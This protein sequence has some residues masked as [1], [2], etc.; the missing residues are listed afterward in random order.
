MNPVF[1]LPSTICDASFGNVPP[2]TAPPPSAT[3]S[4]IPYP[5]GLRFTLRLRWPGFFFARRRPAEFDRGALAFFRRFV[6]ATAFFLLFAGL[7]IVRLI[8]SPKFLRGD[9]RRALETVRRFLRGAGLGLVRVRCF[10][11]VA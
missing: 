8:I 9:L 10:L 1:L 4:R 3:R 2:S 5:P 7:P 6:F 11:A